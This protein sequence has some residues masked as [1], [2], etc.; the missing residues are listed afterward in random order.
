ME[1]EKLV[2]AKEKILE[3]IIEKVNG[4]SYELQDFGIINAEI[5]QMEFKENSEKSIAQSKEYQELLIKA[6]NK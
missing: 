5:N 2:E 3:M 6:L 1:K 4:G